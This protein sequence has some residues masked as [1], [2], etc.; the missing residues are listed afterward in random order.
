MIKRVLYELASPSTNSVSGRVTR[1]WHGREFI[2]GFD[3]E[4][5]GRVYQTGIIFKNVRALQYRSEILETVWQIQDAYDAVVE[6]EQSVWIGDL[7]AVVPVDKRREIDMHH[8]MITLDSVGCFEFAAGSF[9]VM[10]E[11]LVPVERA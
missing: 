8:Y 3:Y 11:L 1:E 5:E 10:P 6:V 4:R 2:L 9:E 7:L